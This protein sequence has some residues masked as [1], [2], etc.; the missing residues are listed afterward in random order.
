M[1]T[2]I[3]MIIKATVTLTME[4][5]KIPTSCSGLLV[6]VF[7]WTN[8]QAPAISSQALWDNLNSNPYHNTKQKC[9][10]VSCLVTSAL[11]GFTL[12]LT[13]P[14]WLDCFI[15]TA[16]IYHCPASHVHFCIATNAESLRVYNC[17]TMQV[18]HIKTI[19]VCNLQ[20]DH[21]RTHQIMTAGFLKTKVQ[22]L[23]HYEPACISKTS[24]KC[25][26]IDVFC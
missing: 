23:R 1:I 10:E 9:S 16:G 6:E 3:T 4:L 11:E 15:V 17:Q 12:P 14:A 2:I 13:P 26:E 25:P 24:L 7:H 20:P 22:M 19:A 5:P 8:I 18:A 21:R